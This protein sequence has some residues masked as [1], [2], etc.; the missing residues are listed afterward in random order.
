MEAAQPTSPPPAKKRIAVGDIIS[1]T[2][3]IYGQQ[4]GVLIG[5]AL[6][7]FVVVGLIS[8]LLQTGGFI[9]GVIGAI[10]NLAGYALYTGFVVELVSDVRDGR[11]DST[12]GDLFEAAMP[13]ILPLIGFGILFG[14]AAGIG[15]FLFIIPGLFLVT[16]WAVG[17]PSIV[18]EN[19][20][21][22]GAFG[23]SRELVRGNGW[24]V[25]GVLLVVFLIVFGIGIVLGIIATPIGNGA[26]IV[27]AIV[28]N[29]LT[30]PIYAITASV[31][32]FELGGSSVPAPAATPT[33][34]PSP[35]GASGPPPPP[36]PP[37]PPAS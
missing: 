1:E 13:Y 31:L 27:A 15:F 4:L 17:A 20:G 9:L 28:A 37:P 21:A 12:V 22:I 33:A 3:S 19:T 16:I 8:G 36:P 14:I 11:R 30:A 6:A 34:P 26:T 23:R 32:F 35:A 5:S 18:V 2:F 24:Q 29:V 7:V 25:L 10:V